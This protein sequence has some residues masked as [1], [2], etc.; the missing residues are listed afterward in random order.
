MPG[1]P[2]TRASASTARVPLPL[3]RPARRRPVAR[4]ALRLGFAAV[5]V[6]VAVAVAARFLPE[7]RGRRGPRRPET[8]A[9]TLARAELPTPAR[10][11]AAAQR[12]PD[13]SPAGC[14]A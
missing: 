13:S 3:R 4:A 6:L 8:A 2:F 12:R 9:A 14:S 7:P 5:V 10:A 1:C 11:D